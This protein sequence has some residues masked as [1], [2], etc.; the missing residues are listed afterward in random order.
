VLGY[1]G[2]FR[3]ALQTGASRI[4]LEM[5]LAAALAIADHAAE[6]ELVPNPLDQAAHDSVAA[7]VAE[8]ART[9]GVAR[10][11]VAVSDL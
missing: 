6:G 2:I 4:T 8:A 1:P 7:A 3:G 5:K 11:D 9:S 10:P